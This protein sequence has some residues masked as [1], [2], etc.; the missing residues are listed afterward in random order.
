MRKS[1]KVT[2]ALGG[3]TVASAIAFGVSV[4]SAPSAQAACS[5]GFFSVSCTQTQPGT[6]HN[7][8]TTQNTTTFSLFPPNISN[9]TSVLNPSGKKPPGQQPH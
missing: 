8:F 5:F 9:N 1:H 6:P 7:N 3:I 2:A 4:A